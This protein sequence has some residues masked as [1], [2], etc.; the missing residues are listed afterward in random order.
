MKHLILLLALTAAA[1][2]EL[3]VPAA[4]AYF[5]PDVNG[6]KISAAKGIIEWSNPKITVS[7]FGE[8]KTPGKLSAAVTVR[9]TKGAAAK[10]RLTLA[11][12]SREAEATG[13]DKLQTVNF[14][15]FNVAKAG[16]T[17]FEL[18]TLGASGPDVE[19]LLLDGVAMKDKLQITVKKSEKSDTRKGRNMRKENLLQF[20]KE[21][22]HV[23]RLCSYEI[24]LKISD[25]FLPLDWRGKF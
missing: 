2:A 7:W 13:A 5:D 15:E 9:L 16:Y 14:G 19:A 17:R 23:L 18:A 10:L 20:M 12:Q 11:G 3:S 21:K 22:I 8:I 25:H 24:K 4:T 1:Q 6:A